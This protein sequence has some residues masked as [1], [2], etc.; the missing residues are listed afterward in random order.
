MAHAQLSRPPLWQKLHLCSQY[1]G[2]ELVLIMQSFVMEPLTLMGRDPSR[3]TGQ[4]GSRNLSLL[5]RTFA[6]AYM[7]TSGNL[8][9]AHPQQ[10]NH[11]R[12]DGKLRN[13]PL[14]RF[15]K[16]AWVA[17]SAKR[18]TSAQVMISQFVSSSPM[19]GSMLMARSLEPVSDSASPSLSAPP[20]FMLC[21]SLSQK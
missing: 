14:Q 10:E 6:A 3:M 8:A 4:G 19:S 11:S 13:L 18:L 17:Q 16:G 5:S 9:C 2:S 1:C 15:G 20:P 21:L 12:N 7:S